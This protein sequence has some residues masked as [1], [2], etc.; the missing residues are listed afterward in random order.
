MTS[1]EKKVKITE[2]EGWLRGEDEWFGLHLMTERELA[3]VPVGGRVLFVSPR[4][5][6]PSDI[7]PEKKLKFKVTVEV[8][9]ISKAEVSPWYSM[10]YD[11]GYHNRPKGVVTDPLHPILW[12]EEARAEYDRGYEKGQSHRPKEEESD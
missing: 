9:E 1:I 10:G 11:D 4:E 7:D 5:F 12:D 8:E 6:F 3:N 2:I